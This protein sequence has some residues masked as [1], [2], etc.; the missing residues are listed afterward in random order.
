MKG[1]HR[2]IGILLAAAVFAGC[3][4]IKPLT[5]PKTASG[6]ADYSV[7]AA[8]GAN[9]TAGF[10]SGGLVDR[11]Q[12]RSYLSLFAQQVGARPLDLP[13]ING[14]GIPPLL[15]IRRLLPPPT[16]IDSIGRNFGAPT[17]FFL[18]TA[19]HNMAIPGALVSDVNDTS[20]YY[21]A[22]RANPYFGLIARQQGSLALQVTTHLNPPATFIAFQFGQNEVLGPAIKGSGTPLLTAVQ[23]AALLKGALDTI[24]VRAPAAKVAVFN[25]PDITLYP[26][27]TTL[28]PTLLDAAG[29]ILRDA[30]GNARYVL[31]PNNVRLIANDYVLLKASTLL[32]SGYG[33]PLG[34]FSYLSGAPVPGN[35]VGLADSMVLSSSEAL[36]LQA[37]IRRYN[38]IIDTT[39]RRHDY[40]R[41]DIDGLFRTAATTGF[42]WHG[43]TYTSKFVTGGLF[44]L[45]G[46]SPNDIM[47]AFICNQLIEAVNGTY[48]STILHLDP[49]QYGTLTSSRAGAPRPGEAGLPPLVLNSGM[50]LRDVFPWRDSALP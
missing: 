4:K 45:D 18:L 19:Y 1:M 25:V 48:G 13:T 32:A 7:V 31:G 47:H 10:Q 38:T 50:M 37:E 16:I 15:R 30:N 33:Y 39:T 49:T 23:F 3:S 28:P 41:V 14:D 24:A 35:G 2:T 29:N 46:V 27:F 11:H 40:V 21:A 36:G 5:A 26:F 42:N 9:I 22:A 34:T 17:N 6:R 43:T 8:L 44:S 20:T 12:T